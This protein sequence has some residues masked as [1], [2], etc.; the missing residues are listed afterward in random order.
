MK[1]NSF[2][3]IEVKIWKDYLPQLILHAIMGTKT[4]KITVPLMLF[5]IAYYL[6]TN[7]KVPCHFATNHD[8]EKHKLCPLS[9][10]ILR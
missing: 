7:K 4:C 2:D 10:D 3:A 8:A 1:S 9:A 6:G 5:N